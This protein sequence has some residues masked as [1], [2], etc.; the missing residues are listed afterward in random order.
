VAA[1][2]PA[3]AAQIKVHELTDVEIRKVMKDAAAEASRIV[4]SLEGNESVGSKV[5]SAQASLAASQVEAWGSVHSAT[6]VG[7]GDAFDAATDLQVLADERLFK[8]AG[9]NS[10][11]W[12]QSMLA[13]SRQGLDSYIS[14]KEFNYTLSQKVYRNTALSR[15]YVER[16]V[17]NG[18]LLGKSAREIAADVKKYIDPA[19]PGGA[20]YAAMRLGRTEVQNAFHTTSIKQFKD[21]P[22]VNVVKWFLSG[23]HP[24]PDACNEY[25]EAVTFAGG[26]A[27]EWRPDDVPAKPHPQCLCYIDGIADPLDKYVAE[28]KSGKF[29]DYIDNQMGCGRQ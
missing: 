13:T 7:I 9:M 28:F 23:S 18:L 24:R 29:D 15:G 11:F 21:T 26:G 22:W 2:A 20:S 14:R 3:L 16:A 6:K 17:N 8:A 4:R 1:V 5:R 19:T 27:G 25:A 10:A 12:R